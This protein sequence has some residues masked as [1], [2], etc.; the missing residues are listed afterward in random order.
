MRTTLFVLPAA[1]ALG[2]AIAAVPA[3]RRDPVSPTPGTPLGPSAAPTQPPQQPGPAEK[4]ASDIGE[5]AHTAVDT[6]A[7]KVDQGAK[8]AGSVVE[9]AAEKV[10]Q[11]AKSAASAVGT[12]VEET[13]EAIKP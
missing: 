1:V 2:F 13:G 4:A 7:E 9:K 8:A 12:A 5:G 10:D 6:A 3:C 11:G